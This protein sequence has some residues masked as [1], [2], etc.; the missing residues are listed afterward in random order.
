[1]NTNTFQGRTLAVI[2]DFSQ[3]E[4]LYLFSHTRRL[5]QAL[6][7]GDRKTVDEYRIDD[8]DFGIYEVFLEDSTRTKESFKN[9]AQFHG[10]KLNSLDVGHS[11]IN[12][13]RAMPIPSIPFAAMIIR[14]LL[15]AVPW[16][17]FADG[18][19]KTERSLLAGTDF[20]CP[21]LHQ[22]RRR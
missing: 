8:G 11:S 18:L 6:L 21:R 17:G 12:K 14:S 7:E 4:R 10:V 5:K 22:C 9:A 19:K 15:S 1:M 16:K 20:P 13:K 2:R 3:E